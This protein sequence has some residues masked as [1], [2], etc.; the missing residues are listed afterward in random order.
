MFFV[1]FPLSPCLPTSLLPNANLFYVYLLNVPFYY[2]LFVYYSNISLVL[3]AAF[4]FATH[5]VAYIINE[6]RLGRKRYKFLSTSRLRQPENLIM[7]YREIDIIFSSANR[8]VGLMLLPFY[9]AATWLV[10]FSCYFLVRHLTVMSIVSCALMGTFALVAGVSWIL[11][12]IMGGYIESNGLK[13]LNSC[14]K[15]RWASTWEKK[16]MLKFVASCRPICLCYGKQFIIRKK[17][18]LMFVQGLS[19]GLVRVLLSV[20]I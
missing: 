2:A 19:R 1:I 14:K 17:T 15:Y 5:F 9:A 10:V 18:V 16:V 8:M 6:L 12:L 11:V 4:Y 3:T 7:T 20:H 13:N